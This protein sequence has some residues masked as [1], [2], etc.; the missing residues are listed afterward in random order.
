MLVCF[1]TPLC[2]MQERCNLKQTYNNLNLL[3]A[4]LQSKL[5]RHKK[6][7]KSIKM[8]Y[9]KNARYTKRYIAKHT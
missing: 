2:K 6:K 4:K 8:G 7:T 9:Q 3:A 1:S 5:Y